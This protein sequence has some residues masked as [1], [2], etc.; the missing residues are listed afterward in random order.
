MDLCNAYSSWTVR[1]WFFFKSDNFSLST[2]KYLCVY[3]LDFI[4]WNRN[5]TDILQRIFMAFIEK[6]GFQ[7]P[8]DFLG[9]NQLSFSLSTVLDYDYN[10]DGHLDRLVVSTDGSIQYFR[11]NGLGG[12]AQITGEA[13]PFAAI[14]VGAG[15]KIALKSGKLVVAAVNGTIRYFELLQQP[16]RQLQ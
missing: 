13:N 11:S 2:Y 4:G 7:N 14:N 1:F 5:E 9:V 15:G 3:S 6:F 12:Y 8:L 16:Q 10:G